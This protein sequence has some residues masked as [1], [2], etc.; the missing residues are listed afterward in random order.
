LASDS[1]ELQV[2]RLATTVW[3]AYGTN[4]LNADVKRHGRDIG[5]LYGRDE[6]LRTDIDKRIYEFEQRVNDKLDGLYKLVVTVGVSVLIGA[7]GIIAAILT[8][9]P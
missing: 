4:G 7:G 6:T 3:G 5:D 2:T 1:L 8:Q 9:G